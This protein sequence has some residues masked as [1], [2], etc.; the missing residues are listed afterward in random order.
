MKNPCS[1]CRERALLVSEGLPSQIG[2]TKIWMNKGQIEFMGK[3]SLG[4]TC[5]IMPKLCQLTHHSW[6]P[7]MPELGLG[8]AKREYSEWEIR[9][10]K[11][12]CWNYGSPIA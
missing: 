6:G 3:L 4:I 10:S 7:E 12:R 2:Q 5:L 9:A 1:F 8:K 11:R